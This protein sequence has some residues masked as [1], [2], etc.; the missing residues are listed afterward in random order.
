MTINPFMYGPGYGHRPLNDTTPFTFRDSYTF[1]QKLDEFLKAVNTVEARELEFIAKV[2]KAVA[3][4]KEATDAFMADMVDKYQDILGQLIGYTIVVDEHTY[5][6]SMMDGSVFESYTIAGVDNQL[7]IQTAALNVKLDE[8]K[9][10]VGLAVTAMNDA[11][12]K[13]SDGWVNVK[14]CGAVGDGLT[15]EYEAFRLACEGGNKTVYV[16]AGE[17]RINHYIQL[18]ANTVIE[19]HPEAVLVNESN[20]EY[21]F[22]NGEYGNSSFSTAYVGPGNITIRGGVFDGRIKVGQF[23]SSCFVGIS[24]AENVLIENC[25]FRNGYSSHLVEI[26]SSRNVTIRNCTFDTLNPA[27]LENREF[28]NID[29][30]FGV[31]YP[32]HGAYDG[33]VCDN[34]TVENCT[35]SGGSDGVGTH[36]QP[37]GNGHHTN[38]KVL[39]NHFS[40]MSAYAITPRYWKNSIISGN[41]IIGS[42]CAVRLS[43]A[44]DILVANNIITGG[45]NTQNSAIWVNNAPRTVLSGNVITP[46]LAD[47]YTEG[48]VISGMSTDCVV[49]IKSVTE[50]YRDGQLRIYPSSYP[51]QVGNTRTILA[52][53]GVAVKLKFP[54]SSRQG[55]VMI[56]TRSAARNSPRGLYWIRC[57]A[58]D[59]TATISPIGTV[60]DQ[61]NVILG[62]GI[63]DSVTVPAD[64]FGVFVGE[65]GYYLFNNSD[66]DRIVDISM[67]GW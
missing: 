22:L 51:V 6:A 17:Y 41:T 12:D 50:G 61:D 43:P 14:E 65:D 58:S 30:S 29:Y 18:E 15:P 44:E 7:T 19:M 20:I 54:G 37:T 11:I 26:N 28:I 8:H 10:E 36:S 38:I 64:K 9:V 31:G 4:G 48:I 2:E 33:T 55:N 46:D 24:H 53:R 67:T 62:V 21:V 34:V 35:F 56:S 16:P 5:R 42:Q 23:R 66:S 47:P 49:D 39:N 1:L 45:G 63:P 13:M 27:G 59:S 52:V 60:A 25:T 32:A 57:G 3:D 40:N